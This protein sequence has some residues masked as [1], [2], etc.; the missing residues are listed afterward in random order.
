[1]A[2][3][4]SPSLSERLTYGEWLAE[5]K[6]TVAPKGSNTFVP[7]SN[8]LVTDEFTGLVVSLLADDLAEA[9]RYVARLGARGIH[10]KLDEV[11][12]SGDTVYRG[13]MERLRPGMAGYRG[14]GAAL[15]RAD[16]TCRTI[17]Q[18]PHVVSDRWTE[19]ITL[20]AFDQDSDACMAMF[21]GAHRYA[22]DGEPAPADVAH[23][24]T[25][26][27]HTLTSYLAGNG[28]AAGSPYRFVQFHGSH[29]RRKQPTI[30]ASHGAESPKLTRNSLLVRI[31]AHV[32]G[33]G[34][35]DLGVCGWTDRGEDR[36]RYLLCA[37]DNL[38]GSMLAHLN[39]RQSFL[40][41]EISQSARDE[42]QSGRGRGYEG[43]L[44]LLSAI[45]LTMN[46][47]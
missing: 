44:S 38:Q 27:F 12:G 36:G 5:F 43:V 14:W 33:A 24:S 8:A 45:R 32:N 2:E 23:T 30:T 35:V 9:R 7:L 13:F 18:A 16:T 31:S 15:V 29:N 46:G 22:N 42:Y 39:L 17:Y 40:H 21:A 28:N 6:R 47:E 41:F 34:F 10:Y 37:T 1:M 19:N 26:L 4:L 25:T 3:Q 20:N 11:T